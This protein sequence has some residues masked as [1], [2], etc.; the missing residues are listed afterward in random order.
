ME[1]CVAASN[2]EV[3]I[4]WKEINSTVVLWKERKRAKV[5]KK[6][7]SSDEVT[8]TFLV[9]VGIFPTAIDYSKRIGISH[10]KSEADRDEFADETFL[11]R[12]KG[13]R[14]NERDFLR[15]GGCKR[16]C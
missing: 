10:F 7:A 2:G 12:T 15:F 9:R 13:E 14:R 4:K 8:V 6:L 11:E 16:S 5:C 1:V 3:S